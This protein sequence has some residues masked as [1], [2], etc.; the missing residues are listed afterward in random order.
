METIHKI[1]FE[2]SAKMKAVP[3]NSVDL[4]VTSPPYPMIKMWD[5]LFCNIDSKIADALQSGKARKAFE[6]MH[7]KLDKTWNEIYRVLK[8]GGFA[9][10]NI[11]D[12][13][14]TINEEFSLFS[15]HTRI[16]QYFLKLGFT[17]LPDILWRKQTN[18]P[19]K[20]MGSGMLPAG[21][22]VTLEHE[23]ILIV[24]KKFKRCFETVE[25]KLNRHES[26]YFWEERN[27]FFSDIWMDIKGTK[28]Y[29]QDKS[30]RLRSAAFPFAVVYRLINMYSVKNDVILDPFLGTGTTVAAAMA[31]GRNSI[32]FEIDEKLRTT[33]SL[34]QKNIVAYSNEVIE[35][36][37]KQHLD[38]ISDRKK[39]NKKIKHTNVHYGFPV[40][41][42]QEKKL[43]L[44]ELIGIRDTREGLFTVSYST[45][46][47]PEFIQF[48]PDRVKGD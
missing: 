32:G 35:N 14:R 48:T 43:L 46:P 40:I 38:F 37:I 44:N 26:A 9:C 11:G 27:I 31:A 15:N 12:A 22:Y 20:F 2:D 29:L 8:M 34:V 13:V 41:T 36:R 25:E 21:A 19:N 23:Y 7:K 30:S 4:V 18:A 28:Q 47:Q 6:L 42:N 5:E 33:V 1:Y 16:L 3:S 24:R 17:V 10:V 45:E 39:S